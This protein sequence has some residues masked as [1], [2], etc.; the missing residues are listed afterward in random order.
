ME[1]F[2]GVGAVTAEMVQKRAAELALINGRARH[3]VS[4]LD[5]E[6]AQRE[7][8]GGSDLDPKDEILEAAPE[9]ER[10]EP[11]AGSSGGK[12]ASSNEDTE[13]SEGR[14]IGEQLISEGVHEAEHN[15][16]LQAAKEAEEKDPTEKTKR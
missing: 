16:M 4:D 11:V 7:L 3:E 6:Q 12:V 2:A 15:Q 14:S 10:W 1:N 9:S 5:L 13:D 8:T